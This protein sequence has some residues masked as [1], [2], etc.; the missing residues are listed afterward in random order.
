[1]H[2]ID[3]SPDCLRCASEIL[4]LPVLQ[5]VAVIGGGPASVYFVE[6]ILASQNISRN[7]RRLTLFERRSRL[8]CGWV[9]DSDTVLGF[10]NLAANQTISRQEKGA[11]LGDRLISALAALRRSGMEICIR[12]G[13]EVLDVQHDGPGFVVRGDDGKA[14]RVDHIV[15]ASG[16]W[17][18]AN[19]YAGHPDW[20][21]SPWPASAL[22]ER[23]QGDILLIGASHTAIDAALTLA[24]GAGEFRQVNHQLR[25]IPKHAC[26][27]TLASRS[28]CL[29]RVSGFGTTSGQGDPLATQRYA[30]H[31]L[32]DLLVE[33]ADP[34]TGRVPLEA[35]LSA[36]LDEFPLK[37]HLG[38]AGRSATAR[39]DQWLRAWQSKPAAAM[40]RTD[41][42][43]SRISLQRQRH[44]PWQ[45]LLWEKTDI[46]RIALQTL[47]G[48]DRRWLD[49][50]ETAL[51]A[52]QRTLNH[53][54]ATRLQALIEAGVLTVTKLAGSVRPNTKRGV[55]VSAEDSPSPHREFDL[56]VDCRGQTKSIAAANSPLLQS[57][58]R[59][60]LIQPT[61]VPCLGS[62]A[63][64]PDETVIDGLRYYLPG[65]I[66]LNPKTM[67]AIPA[68]QQHS[69]YRGEQGGI[70]V[71]GP[72]TL[73]QYPI[74]DG[75][76]A[77]SK[78]AQLAIKEIHRRSQ[79]RQRASLVGTGMS[80][81]VSTDASAPL[82]RV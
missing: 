54:N 79:L 17:S 55:L 7:F 45:G 28:G 69:A 56:A 29:P 34:N 61:L 68:G 82:S 9:Y 32:P 1:M 64:G 53:W 57:L 26:T 11:E 42:E 37:H 25:F 40:L 74:S 59:R 67:E 77:L 47:G 15:L 8:G 46:F 2:L 72:A 60:G 6:A 18:A 44:I 65:G 22:R 50:R 13:V 66:H 39:L 71:L 21:P 58:L 27:I 14:E 75:L 43:I 16:H 80:S 63:A 5:H 51:L 12:G 52:H 36:L 3:G 76:H 62:G 23:A 33:A 30:S 70:F 78:L 20:L 48:E 35:I 41:L 73:G 24:D 38:M 4:K 19:P 31:L 10:H 49:Q 81:V